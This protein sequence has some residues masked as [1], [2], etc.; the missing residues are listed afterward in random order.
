MSRTIKSDTTE[1]SNKMND[2]FTADGLV[3][4]VV[5]YTTGD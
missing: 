4:F 2:K 5:V 3:C 1:H